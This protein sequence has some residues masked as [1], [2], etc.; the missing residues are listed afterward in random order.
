VAKLPVRSPVSL[1]SLVIKMLVI[2]LILACIGLVV[3]VGYGLYTVG[4]MLVTLTPEQLVT[5]GVNSLKGSAS[6][7]TS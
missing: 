6:T 5:A 4:H 7:A 2:L 3:Y 1:L